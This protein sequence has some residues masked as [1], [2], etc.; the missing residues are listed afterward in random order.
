M[1]CRLNR[2]ACSGKL[3]EHGAC[4]QDC[5]HVV[6]VL[7]RAQRA[8]EERRHYDPEGWRAMMVKA[9]VRQAASQARSGA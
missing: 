3:R 9:L 4:A 7:E 6:A 2:A 1:G 5:A 8:V